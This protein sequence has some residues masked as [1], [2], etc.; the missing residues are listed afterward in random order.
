MAIV[1]DHSTLYMRVCTC[2]LDNIIDI[3]QLLYL[4][5]KCYILQIQNIKIVIY[6]IYI[7]SYYNKK[8]INSFVIIRDIHFMYIALYLYKVA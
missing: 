6:I 4:L 5:G 7:L 2:A 3:L 1:L 8:R